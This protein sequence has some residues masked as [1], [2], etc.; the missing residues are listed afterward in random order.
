MTRCAALAALMA[1]ALNAPPSHAEAAAA[2]YQDLLDRPAQSSARGSQAVLLAITRAGERI[3]AVGEFGI[4]L[5]SDDNGGAWRQAQVPVSVALTNVRFASPQKGWAVGHAGVVLSTVDGGETWA[6]QLDGRQAAELELTAA[7]AE[8][9][10]GGASAQARL[11]EAERLV[12]DGADKPFLD[13][14]FMDANRG[15]LIGAY[16]L[17]FETVDGGKS[18]QS[19]KGHIDNP[20]GKH[21]YSICVA[22]SGI[23]LAGEQGALYRSTDSG[24]SFSEVKT[25]YVGTY[26]GV[27]ASAEALV[28]Y[29]LRGH[30]YRSDDAGVTWERI[31]LGI[32]TMLP[33]A[34]RLG[35]GSL[36][37]VDETGRVL[38]SRHDAIDF[39][40]VPVPNPS[41]FTGVVQGGDGDLVLSGMRGITR[42]R[43]GE[44]LTEAPQ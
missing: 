22:P 24:K 25:P 20:K 11:R 41:P 29:G 15:L 34:T 2:G 27:I 8:G 4:V 10:A 33:A 19:L 12:A 28:V 30:A 6:K 18:W 39:I 7:R 17:I 31:D 44:K 1:A 14:Y 43:L 32:S 9:G 36:V 40:S 38:R 37:L 16:G 35:D 13:I 26:F 42:L 3:V 23:Y 5:L 21:L